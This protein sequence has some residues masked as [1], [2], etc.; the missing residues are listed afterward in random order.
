MNKTLITFCFLLISWTVFAQ[1]PQGFNYQAVVRDGQG[2]ILANQTVGLQLTI[3]GIAPNDSLG[4]QAFVK[5]HQATTNQHGLINLV[6]NEGESDQEHILYGAIEGIA[7][8]D[9]NY[10]LEVAMDISDSEDCTSLTPGQ[11]CKVMGIQQLLAV[12]Y[13]LYAEKSGSSENTNTIW[14]ETSQSVYVENK[15]IGI[16]TAT[17][18]GTLEILTNENTRNALNL[19]TSDNNAQSGIT[20]QNS[21]GWYS[22]NMYRAGINNDFRIAGRAAPL[23]EL[24]DFVTIKNWSGHIGIGTNSPKQ[25]LHNTGAYY[26]KGELWLHATNGDGMNGMTLIQ[27]R[28]NTDSSN[29]SMRLRTQ[30]AGA[31]QDVMHLTESGYVGIGEMTPQSKLHIKGNT[32]NDLTLK[33]SN[34]LS[35][36]GIA[37]QN[38]A[39]AY[40]WNI[41]RKDAG[42]NTADLTFSG[43]GTNYAETNINSLSTYLTLKAGGNIGISTPEPK[44]KLHISDGDIYIEDI[45]SGIIMKD[46]ETGFCY[47]LRI[48]NGVLE[49]E[50]LWECP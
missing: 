49:T 23:E 40:T 28:D 2:A 29:I 44:S 7:W 4:F 25:Q 43:N 37:F 32:A 36:Q 24:M 11:N 34:N 1:P 17:P 27:A 12:P 38:A 6:I 47:R 15:K 26:G 18:K 20:W 8:G 22:W 48:V 33:T 13:A 21:G 35:N 39:G 50:E 19:K 9:H 5:Y 42:N 10:F 16:G 31:P 41:Y 30:K 46:A 3:W 14:N 45:N